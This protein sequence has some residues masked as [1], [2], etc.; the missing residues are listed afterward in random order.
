MNGK[1]AYLA[2]CSGTQQIQQVSA[3]QT[4]RSATVMKWWN[5]IFINTHQKLAFLTMRGCF[6]PKQSIFSCFQFKKKKSS[7]NFS[8]FEISADKIVLCCVFFFLKRK[9]YF[10]LQSQVFTKKTLPFSFCSVLHCWNSRHGLR[11][12]LGWKEPF[13]LGWEAEQ[14]WETYLQRCWNCTESNNTQP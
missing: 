2:T 11:I 1:C 5:I 13:C 8:P 7:T 6:F 12:C 14:F 4:N 3:S 10:S 9:K